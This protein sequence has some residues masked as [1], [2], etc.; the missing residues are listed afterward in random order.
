MIPPQ[1]VILARVT[2]VFVSERE[3][4]SGT[5]FRNGIMF[6]AKPPPVSMLNRSAG[7]N[8]RWTRTGSVCVMFAILNRTCIL[9]R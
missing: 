5:K 4:H 3:L 2:P 7:V 1:N 6:N 9:S 8:C